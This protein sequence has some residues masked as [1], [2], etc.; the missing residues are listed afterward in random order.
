MPQMFLPGE[1]LADRRQ[2]A[3]RLLALEAATPASAYLQLLP[4]GRDPGLRWPEDRWGP[5]LDQLRARAWPLGKLPR[6][7]SPR[8]EVPRRSTLRGIIS[9]AWPTAPHLPVLWTR[10]SGGWA[11]GVGGGPESG[12]MPSTTHRASPAEVIPHAGGL[13]HRGGSNRK[14]GPG[15]M[16]FLSTKIEK[17]GLRLGPPGDDTIERAEEHIAR[18]TR[19]G[20]REGGG[21]PPAG[22]LPRPGGAGRR[23]YIAALD[24]M[25]LRGRGHP[26]CATRARSEEAVL[27]T[28]AI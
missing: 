7:R 5:R 3:D 11:S 26:H 9:Q 19:L 6:R 20:G 24:D 27:W 4:R 15:R 25:G 18:L 14:Y 13:V 10:W 23:A 8:P 22:H 28:G 1:V 16:P 12:C 2:A 21:A 17:A